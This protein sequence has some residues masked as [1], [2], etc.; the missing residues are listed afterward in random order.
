M[1]EEDT[2]R[3]PSWGSQGRP[4]SGCQAPC[5][6]PGATKDSEGASVTKVLAASQERQIGTQIRVM[7][8]LG[9]RTE[10]CLRRKAV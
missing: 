3:N 10:V 7:K 5:W 1:A 8:G 2:E 4:L 6:P 9:V